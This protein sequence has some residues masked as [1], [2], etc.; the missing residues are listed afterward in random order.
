MPATPAAHGDTAIVAGEVTQ[1]LNPENARGSRSA[2]PPLAAQQDAWQIFQQQSLDRNLE[3]R[4]SEE[5]R[6][7]PPL[8]SLT[9]GLD[10][11]PRPRQRRSLDI[12][13]CGLGLTDL[14]PVAQV[15]KMMMPRTMADGGSEAAAA[16]LC[17][18]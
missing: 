11:S 9:D 1:M 6:S 10:A 13:R 3:R 18:C 17:R 15:R 14:E 7:T 5:S 16:M 8:V 12:S 2:P 4:P